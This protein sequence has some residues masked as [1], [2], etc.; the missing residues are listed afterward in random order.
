MP[1]REPQADATERP[2][3]IRR[4]SQILVKG[5]VWSPTTERTGEQIAR[6]FQQDPAMHV[7]NMDVA[8][9]WET[10]LLQDVKRNGHR[11][12]QWWVAEEVTVPTPPS[13]QKRARKGKRQQPTKAVIGC[14]GLSI[15]CQYAGCTDL[16]RH[17]GATTGLVCS[18]FVQREHRRRGV[19]GALLRAVCRERGERQPL[20]C[21]TSEG[22][23][24]GMLEHAGFKEIGMEGG[25]AK[26][27]E[28]IRSDPD[29][30]TRPL[31][32]NSAKNGGGGNIYE[33]PGMRFFCR[34]QKL[35]AA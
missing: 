14:V 29:P 1:R 20:F 17:A 27:L 13:A 24:V 16:H 19:C 4:L 15:R 35:L 26:T 10:Y 33:R 2:F 30:A 32:W 21:D 9:E 11:D 31:D 34:Q 6:L 3:R 7:R 5:G 25:A 28:E 23:L 12:L 18:M 22:F 8:E